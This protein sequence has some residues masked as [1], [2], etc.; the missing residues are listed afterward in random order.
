MNTTVFNN[1]I[2]YCHNDTENYILMAA[3][4]DDI[5]LEMLLNSCFSKTA[6]KIYLSLKF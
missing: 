6:A 4:E 3:S 5:I 2:V 1:T